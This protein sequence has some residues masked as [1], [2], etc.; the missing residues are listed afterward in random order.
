MT[1]R[2]HALV[3]RLAIPV[4]LAVLPLTLGAQ[5]GAIQSPD[6]VLK[7]S[8]N[9]SPPKDLADGQQIKEKKS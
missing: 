6:D 5:S 7:Q 1:P 9:Q 8:T 3:W 4:A 2:K